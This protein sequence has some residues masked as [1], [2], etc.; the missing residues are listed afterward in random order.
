MLYESSSRVIYGIARFARYVHIYLSL[1]EVIRAMRDPYCELGAWNFTENRSRAEIQPGPQLRYSNISR[2]R[3]RS[4]LWGGNRLVKFKPRRR[5]HRL[6]V[7]GAE[8]ISARSRERN[9]S[10]SAGT[11]RRNDSRVKMAR[12]GWFRA[13][14]ALLFSARSRFSASLSAPRKTECPLPAEY[15]LSPPRPAFSGETSRGWLLCS[16]QRRISE[17]RGNRRISGSREPELLSS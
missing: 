8:R 17:S 1:Y 3:F 9:A 12:S 6:E 5:L 14:A 10:V 7:I 4:W 15:L 2:S 11:H 13:V 16:W